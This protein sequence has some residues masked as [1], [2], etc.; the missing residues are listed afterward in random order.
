MKVLPLAIMRYLILTII[1]IIVIPLAGAIP[2]VGPIWYPQYLALLFFSIMGISLFLWDFNKYL[3]AFLV[4][5]LLSTF[6]ITKISPRAVTLL[7]QLS[8]CL[9]IVYKISSFDKKQRR[10]ILFAVLAFAVINNIWLVLQAHNKDFIFHLLANPTQDGM[11]G[12]L[13]SPDQVGIYSSLI[14]PVLLGLN[15]I[16]LGL[17][18][19]GLFFSKSSFAVVAAISGCLFY[20]FYVNKKLFKGLVILFL[21]LG[22]LFFLKV[23]RLRSIDFKTR[24]GVW[25]HAIESTVKG[26]IRIRKKR[27]NLIINSKPFLG[28]GFGSFLTIFPYVPQ[29]GDFNYVDEKFT[30]A[31]NDYVEYFFDLGIGFI[32][33]LLL[34]T[35]MVRRFIKARKTKELM[36]YSSGLLI[37]GINSMGHCLSQFAVPGLFLLLYLGMFFGVLREQYESA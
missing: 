19:A 12:F 36:I 3:S 27:H 4:I 23:D 17:S 21:V 32:I 26:E 8:I 31:H 28:F 9:L 37:Y 15:P 18:L 22:S 25:K 13:G 29:Q 11:V 5:C 10:M 2:T 24:T 6:F 33:I 14:I 35:D 16:L 7:W 20:S 1:A 30:H 34:M